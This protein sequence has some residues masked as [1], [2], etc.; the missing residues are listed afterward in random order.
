MRPFCDLGKWSKA[1]PSCA[2]LFSKS[3][4]LDP[5]IPSLLVFPT[6][7]TALLT[8][9]SL[10]TSGQL[11]LQ[12]KASHFPSFVLSPP[13]N[14]VVIDGTAAPGNKTTHLSALMSNRGRIDAFELSPARW[15]VLDRMVKRAGCENVKVGNEG[16]RNFLETDPKG[17]EWEAVTFVRFESTP[18]ISSADF[19]RLS[20]TYPA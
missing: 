18:S 19:L 11:I 7:S 16:G 4:H 17:K 9:S 1:Q 3:F 13:P 20:Q 14:A 8:A 2:L 5:H 10:Y 6:S 15:K 12:D